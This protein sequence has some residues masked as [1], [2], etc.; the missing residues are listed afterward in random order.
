MK[1]EKSIVII[2]QISSGKTTLAKKLSEDF[3]IPLASFGGY[4]KKQ[5]GNYTDSISNRQVLQ[6]IGQDM[7]DRDALGFL[8]NVIEFS[9]AREKLIFEGVRHEVIFKAIS[10]LS[11]Y[12]IS[13]YID[14]SYTQR[15]Q[16]YLTREKS[17]DIKKS[18]EE[19]LKACSHE[20]EL[21][22][23]LLMDKSSFI[24]KSSSS[25]EEDYKRVKEYV[26]HW[27]SLTNGT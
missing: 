23:P 5:I 9:D 20:V 26:E 15:L 27:N 8:Q 11:H 22:I 1:L 14:A 18:E 6:N 17:I 3:D 24:I 25:Q 10:G 21:Q 13:I 19:F 12:M 2:G 16:R 7:V 4:L